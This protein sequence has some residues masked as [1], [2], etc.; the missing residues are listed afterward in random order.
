MSASPARIEIRSFRVVFA[1]ERRIHHIDH[2]RIPVPYGLPVR[3]LAYAV[4]ALF[5]TVVVGRLPLV[6][7]AVGLVPAPLRL[8]VW[9]GAVG[10][11]LSRLRVDGRPAHG[12]LLAL[13]RYRLGPRYLSAF[14]AAPPPGSRVRISEPIAFLPDERGP[15]LRR[16]RVRGAAR[17]RLAYPMAAQWRG[18]RLLLRQTGAWPLE[19]SRVLAADDSSTVVFR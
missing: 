17:L 4:A 6:G 19:R 1:L 18:R 9:P 3:A 10:F 11:A 13:A 7:E 15:R 12:F 14:R 16:G 8:V 5:V 2:W